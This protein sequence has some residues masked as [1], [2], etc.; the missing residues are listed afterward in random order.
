MRNNQEITIPFNYTPRPYQIDL[1]QAITK[2][3]KKRA[4]YVWH[5]RAGKDLIALNIIMF[6][7]VF[8]QV[9]TYWHIFPSYA[10]GKK[11]IWQETDASGRK[12]LDYFPNKLIARKNEKDLTITFKNG[13]IYQIVG[14]DNPDSL[15]GAGIKGAVFSEYAEQDVRAWETI[16]PMLLATNGWAIFNFTPKGQ[17]HSYEL[18]KM[19]KLSKNWHCE[20]KTAEETGVFTKEQLEQ[21]KEEAIAKGKTL[22]YFNQEYMCSF[23]NPIEGAYYS[24]LIKELEDKKQITNVPYEPNLPVQTWWDLGVGDSTAIW[25][26]QCVGKEIRVIDYLES[27][28]VGLVEYI[29]E[30]RNKNYIYESHNAP[31]DIVVREF[32]SGKARIDTARELGFNFNIVPDIPRSDGID[33]VRIILNKCWFDETKCKKG[34]IALNNYKKE[35]DIK[36]N[37]FYDTPKHDWSS[38]GADAFRYLAVGYQD[39]I[40]KQQRQTHYD[41]QQTYY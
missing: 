30:I 33:A 29:R 22:D 18:F 9:G 6:Q 3:E 26:T 2:N 16:E 20:I 15:R 13:S 25:F 38:D 28:G 39:M 34:L 40:E 1:W 7:A 12:Y 41:Y 27:S 35:F 36:R 21:V 23:T 31:H 8:N 11:A 37:C 17:N 32:T 5:R 10:Q 19:A 24:H 14:S 4:L